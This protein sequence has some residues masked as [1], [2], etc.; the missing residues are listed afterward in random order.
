MYDSKM[1]VGIDITGQKVVVCFEVP[2]GPSS[3]CGHVVL[4]Q[5]ELNGLIFDLRKAQEAL[6][7]GQ[8]L[9]LPRL[10]R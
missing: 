8:P 4:S 9:N 7:P 3:L 2:S 6:L 10:T 1:S 5:E